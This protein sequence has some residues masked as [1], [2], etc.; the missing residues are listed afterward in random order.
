VGAQSLSRSERKR[1]TGRRGSWLIPIVA[2]AGIV[3]VLATTGFLIAKVARGVPTP[4]HTIAAETPPLPEKPIATVD[5]SG[6]AGSASATVDASSGPEI[7]VP[8]VVGK[9][10]ATAE[11]LLSGAGFSTQTRVA[12]KPTAGVSANTV[13][14][15]WPDA[16]ARLV[17][18]DRVVLTYEPRAVVTKPTGNKFVVV[19]DPGHQAVADM[20]LEPIGPGSKTEKPKVAGGATGD[21]TGIPEYKGVLDISL[22]LRTLLQAKGITVVMVR[23]TNDV[24]IPN[25]RRAKIGNDAHADLVVRVHQDSST[26]HSVHGVLTL[27]PAGNSW[28]APIERP[29][30]AA[31][32]LMESEM[33]KVTGASSRGLEAASDMSG[34]NYSTV[35]SIIVEC[36][37]LS[38]RDEDERM[39]TQAYRERLAQGLAA[40]VMAYL[41]TK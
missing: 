8:N 23:T 7:E 18:G 9:P 28:V 24:D 33:V 20:G 26:D 36:G 27:Y 11:A 12:D 4:V 19:I 40:G 6:T 1:R 13:V 29:S 41:A 31:A 30:R 10:V 25:S 16:G 17:A 21:Y 15:Q 39:A 14:S 22:K 34:F 35:P 3:V 5:G 37:L 32:S 2:T 38:N